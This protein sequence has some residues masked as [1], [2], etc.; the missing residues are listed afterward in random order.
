MSPLQS[1]AQLTSIQIANCFVVGIAVAALAGA[2]C[3]LARR[4]RSAMRFVIWFAGLIAI[5]SLFF[6]SRPIGHSA[7]THIGSA[8]ARAWS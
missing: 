4:Q 1:L 5:A 3:T 6:F 2:G 8:Q 7:A